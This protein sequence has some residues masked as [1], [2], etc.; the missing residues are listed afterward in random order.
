MELD[1]IGSFDFA[2]E[3]PTKVEINGHT[4]YRKTNT[5]FMDNTV[6]LWNRLYNPENGQ[7][8]L[9]RSAIIHEGYNYFPEIGVEIPHLTETQKKEICTNV[10]EKLNALR[11]FHNEVNPTN[12]NLSNVRMVQLENG[13]GYYPI[14]M[15]KI[16]ELRDGAAAE[17]TTGSHIDD[18]ID[19]NSM[20]A[21]KKRKSRHKRKNKR[22]T[23]KNKRKTI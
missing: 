5:G 18:D 9:F 8:L 4:Y 22:K 1:D 21:G 14:D 23:R 13:I 12:C 11:L 15:L 16:F 6:A 20:F 17:S 7:L 10:N 2:L 19:Y 3:H